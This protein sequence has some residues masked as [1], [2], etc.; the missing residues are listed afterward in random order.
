MGHGA[1][2]LRIADFG[3]RILKLSGVTSNIF[4]ALCLF[5]RLSQFSRFSPLAISTEKNSMF[6][7]P[8]TAFKSSSRPSRLSASHS[9]R[10]TVSPRRYVLR[11]TYS[12]STTLVRV[13]GF[14]SFA[15]EGQLIFVPEIVLAQAVINEIPGQ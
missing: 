6:R 3:L 7:V 13:T 2:L 9:L 8:A 1:K 14:G 15:G 10:C 12:A 11:R 5:S 4:S